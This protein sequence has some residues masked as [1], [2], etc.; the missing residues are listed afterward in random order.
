MQRNG[1]AVRT[2]ITVGK[3]EKKDDSRRNEAK[4]EKA[5]EDDGEDHSVRHRAS[6]LQP[7]LDLNPRFNEC[8]VS[9]DPIDH[10]LGALAHCRIVEAARAQDSLLAGS[11]KADAALTPSGN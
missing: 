11:L 9:F 10:D 4:H 2:T 3:N 8:E 5:D 1:I 7:L 6:P